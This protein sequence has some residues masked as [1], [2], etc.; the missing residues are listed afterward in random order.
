MELAFRT[1]NNG[2]RLVFVA[3][4]KEGGEAELRK[5]WSLDSVYLKSN[6]APDRRNIPFGTHKIP[7]R[8][9]LV[10][11]GFLV[12]IEYHEERISVTPKT[13]QRNKLEQKSRTYRFDDLGV[14]YTPDSDQFNMDRRELKATLDKL[15]TSDE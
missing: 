9:S 5:S 3:F 6:G 7:N 11:G 15:P 4:P 14:E 12:K 2:K 13:R 1:Y 10:R 8:K